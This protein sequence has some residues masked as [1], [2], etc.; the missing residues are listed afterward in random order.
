MS[1]PEAPL[2]AGIVD[3]FESKG[4]KTFGASQKAAELEASKSFAKK[5]MN[6]YNIPTARG[7]TFTAAAKAKAYV[8][9]MGAPIVVKA[10]GL[11]AGKGVFVCATETEAQQALN[12][13]FTQK[14]FGEAGKKVVIE[15]VSAGRRKKLLP[16][17]P[18]PTEKTVLPLPSSQDHKAIFDGDK[19]PNTGGM[20]AYSPAPIVTG[21][22]HQKIMNEVMIPTVRAMAA[23]GRKYKG[24]LYAGLMIDND[25]IRVLEFN[26]P[27]RR[28]RSPAPADAAYERHCPHYGGHP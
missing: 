10:D 5:L 13:I 26:A 16:F 3:L 9:T 25:R 18:L 6:K 27:V 1:V 23:E 28:S 4:L 11:A 21:H 2:A 8:K 20:G 17:W 22:L 24:V 7:K 15:G 19:G 14:T 12:Q